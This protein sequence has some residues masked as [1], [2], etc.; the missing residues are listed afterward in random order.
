MWVDVDLRFN[1]ISPNF[2]SHQECQVNVVL[3]AGN[4][5]LWPILGCY[6]ANFAH[7]DHFQGPRAFAL[8]FQQI[9]QENFSY[10]PP[11]WDQFMFI[12]IPILEFYLIKINKIPYTFFLVTRKWNNCSPLISVYGRHTPSQALWINVLRIFLPLSSPS[13]WADLYFFIYNI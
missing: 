10:K 4:A 6:C 2:L 12:L 5:L 7:K 11:L 8:T 3:M 9:S 13:H 1:E